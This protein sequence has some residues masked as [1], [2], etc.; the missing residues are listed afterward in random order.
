MKPAIAQLTA[1]FATDVSADLSSTPKQ[2]QSK[3]LY[4]ALGSSLFDAIC[5]LPWYRITRAESA[6]LAKHGDA[7]VA[8]IGKANGT[9]VELGCGS[10]EK[11]V[12]LAEAL[13]ARGA[14]AH[15]HLIDISPQAIEHTEQRLTRLR[16]VRVCQCLP[17][18]PLQ[19]PI[20][21]GNRE[22]ESEVYSL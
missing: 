20:A 13:Q 15:V 1:Q 12:L 14:S 4:D 2:L 7:I 18:Q 5:R 8:S 6:L 10:G 16:C 3:Y 19:V 9:I 11:L 22:P 21:R 17:A